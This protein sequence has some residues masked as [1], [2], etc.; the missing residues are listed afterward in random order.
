VSFL[1]RPSAAKQPVLPAD[2][3][4]LAQESL[5]RAGAD[6]S[7]PH[8]TRHFIFVPGVLNAQRAARALRRGD[9]DIGIDTSA[10]KGYWLVTI[11][12]TMDITAE[13]AAAVRA[14]FE[15]AVHPLGGEYD[16]WHVEPG[17]VEPTVD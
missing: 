12:Q 14:E 5:V 10:R 17:R 1:R 6:T 7:Q 3:L 13:T 11:V 2:P 8:L 15:A 16:T 9:R 4:A